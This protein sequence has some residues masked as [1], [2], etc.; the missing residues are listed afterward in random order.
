MQ[1]NGIAVYRSAL[2]TM[3]LAT[4]AANE[5]REHRSSNTDSSRLDDRRAVNTLDKS[6]LTHA[7]STCQRKSPFSRLSL[8]P[9]SSNVNPA[10]TGFGLQPLGRHASRSTSSLLISGPR[11]PTHLG[12]HPV[13]ICPRPK[14][15]I[16]IVLAYR[17]CQHP[18]PG[19]PNA[20][21]NGQE[22]RF[23]AATARFFR[24]EQRVGASLPISASVRVG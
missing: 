19:F 4:F 21:S 16:R 14:R 1:I 24:L 18:G 10:R 23:F 2:L 8:L 6:Q 7:G 11:K 22:N 17:P 13:G 12:N 3:A 5:I 20:L 15:G 9:Q